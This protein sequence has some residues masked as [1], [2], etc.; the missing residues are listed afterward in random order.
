MKPARHEREL[1]VDGGRTSSQ[2]LERIVEK[3]GHPRVLIVGDLILDRYVSGE[4]TRISPEAPIPILTAK[5]SEAL[6]L[7]PERGRSQGLTQFLDEKSYRPGL[8]GYKR[9]E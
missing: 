2:E 6:F 5:S 3:A 1:P 7:D 8:S 9:Q 4:V